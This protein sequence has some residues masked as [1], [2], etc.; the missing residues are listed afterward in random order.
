MFRK[1]VSALPFSPAMVGQLGFYARRLQREQFIRR[2]GL[3]FVVLAVAVQFLTLFRPPEPTVASSPTN[4]CAFNSSLKRQDAACKPCPYDANIWANDKACNPSL[5]RTIEATN[6]SSTK[7]ANKGLAFAEDRIQYN[8]KTTNNAPGKNTLSV[9][10]S[11]SDLLEYGSVIDTGGGTFD[12]DTKKITWGNIVLNPGQS[13]TRSFVLQLDGN[14]PTT[15]QAVDNVSSYDCALTSTY[16][17]R[18]TVQIACPTSKIV[19]TTIRKLPT[20]SLATNIVFA[21][22]LTLGTAYFYFRSR[23][24]ARELKLVRKDFNPGPM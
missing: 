12:A 6:L 7:P 11:V 1:L 16:G 10:T 8:L 2:L 19:E 18:L 15:P 24:L 20:V 17:N 23:L 22:V 5:S 21:V 14:L 3:L 13:D 9:E 4:S